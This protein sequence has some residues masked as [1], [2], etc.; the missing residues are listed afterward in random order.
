MRLVGVGGD[1]GSLLVAGSWLVAPSGNKLAGTAAVWQKNKGGRQ[2]WGG[3]RR[4]RN[5]V[6]VYLF[7]V[8][9]DL[10]HLADI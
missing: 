8:C 4:G 7:D 5:E 3:E 10:I 2:Q 6:S 1:E 9:L